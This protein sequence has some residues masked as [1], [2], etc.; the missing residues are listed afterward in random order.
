MIVQIRG[1]GGS[2][3]SRV[4][5]ELLREHR[6]VVVEEPTFYVNGVGSYNITF[7]VWRCDGD[8]YVLGDYNL[9]YVEG[10]YDPHN[11]DK[12]SGGDKINGEISRLVMRHYART[13]Q[14]GHHC[15]WESKRGSTEP[16][17]RGTTAAKAKAYDEWRDEIRE[18]GIVWAV[19]DTPREVALANTFERRKERRAKP[20][21]DPPDQRNHEYVHSIK[22]KGAEAGIRVVDIDYKHAYVEL[23][24]LL[25]SGGWE[26]ERH[27]AL[28][29]R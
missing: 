5:R 22:N 15:I 21:P 26:C 29:P 16:R 23:H 19:L 12:G 8:L 4:V 3:K 6:G 11:K 7:Q 13:S 27:A 14:T 9:D 25:V 1:E 2:G 28:A 18:L 17:L 24:E 20:K 10:E